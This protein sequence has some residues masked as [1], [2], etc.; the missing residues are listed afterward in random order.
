MFFP[1]G[2]F[3]NPEKNG[4]GRVMFEN[5]YIHSKELMLSIC[6]AEDFW[7]SIGLQG[8]QTSQS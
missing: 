7:E 6:G 3:Q 2:V 1:P 8:D 5:A 4:E